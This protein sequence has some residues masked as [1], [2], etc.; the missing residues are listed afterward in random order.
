MENAADDRPDE[1]IQLEGIPPS[2]SFGIARLGIRQYF[3]AEHLWAARLMAHLC[4]ERENQLVAEGAAR[5]IDY[6]IRSFALSAIS[7]SVATLEAQVN[8]IWQDAA[9]TEPTEDHYRLRGLS[10]AARALMR[11]L[12]TEKAERS[13]NL[14]EKYALLLTCAGKGRLDK[15]RRP[16]PDVKVNRPGNAGGS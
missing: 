16:Y 15:S 1:T 13:L 12:R 7:E 9:E 10:P 6:H 4:R 3:A 8:E 5:V 11:D 2:E 14:I